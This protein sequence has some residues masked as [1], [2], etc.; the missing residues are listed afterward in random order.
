[1]CTA[2]IRQSAP[3]A[4]T[5]VNLILTAR[6]NIFLRVIISS[7][8]TRNLVSLPTI[9]TLP[10]E[11]RDPRLRLFPA[12]LPGI[13]LVRAIS[14]LFY[15]I[16]YVETHTYN[17]SHNCYLDIDCVDLIIVVLREQFLFANDVLLIPGALYNTQY[18]DNNI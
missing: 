13:S 12:T 18:S 6:L 11:T 3:T 16:D 9:Y 1:M 4:A 10:P 5:Y 14:S 15:V 7:C 2:T 8:A 17:T